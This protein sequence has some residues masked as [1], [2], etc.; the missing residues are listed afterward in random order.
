MSDDQNSTSAESENIQADKQNPTSKETTPKDGQD[1]SI[2]PLL[3]RSR[4]RTDKAR[5]KFF[6][7]VK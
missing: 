4:L 5:L 6:K 7:I 2:K 3:L 1:F